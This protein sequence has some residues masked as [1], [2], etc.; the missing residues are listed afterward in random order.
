MAGQR[1]SRA[2]ARFGSHQIEIGTDVEHSDLDQ[3]ID[4]NEFTTVRL[5]NSLVR[6][7]QFL[8][9]PRQFRTTSRRTAI[10][11]D[12]WRP[13]ET[14][15]VEGGFRTQWDEYTGDA[16]RRAETLGGVVSEVVGRRAILGGMGNLLRCDHAGHAG[17]EPG[18]DQ[19][20]HVL[21]ADGRSMIGVPI[22]TQFV[23]QPRNLRCRVS[24]SPVSRQSG[25]CPGAFT[26]RS[27]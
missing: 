9:S 17:A 6:D 3:T 22:E 24:R 7:V 14:L 16:P 8:G 27:T 12:R 4:R 1:L 21:R 23:L 18:A 5:D 10:A 15:V 26:A 19:H 25:S 20:Q 2:D 11:L 13:I